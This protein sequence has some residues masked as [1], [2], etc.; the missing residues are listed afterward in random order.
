MF[1]QHKLYRTGHKKFVNNAMFVDQRRFGLV[2]FDFSIKQWM[3]M[4]RSL[5]S[6]RTASADL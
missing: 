5:R 2:H 3:Q 6:F 1:I 4:L